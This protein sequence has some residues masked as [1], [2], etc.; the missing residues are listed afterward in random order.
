MSSIDALFLL[1]FY[2]W[3]VLAGLAFLVW[4][5]ECPRPMARRRS[6]RF[7]SLLHRFR[8]LRHVC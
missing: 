6:A 1:C 8:R 5:L 3:P 2:A 7:L 4:Y